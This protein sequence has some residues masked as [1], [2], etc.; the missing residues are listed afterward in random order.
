MCKDGEIPFFRRAH[1]NMQAINQ[2]AMAVIDLQSGGFAFKV[3]I[4]DFVFPNSLC[5]NTLTRVIWRVTN[6]LILH[7]GLIDNLGCQPKTPLK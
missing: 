4:K 7:F 3:N 2:Q 5:K 6:F 1:R